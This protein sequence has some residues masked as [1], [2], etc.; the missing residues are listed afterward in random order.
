MMGGRVGQALHTVNPFSITYFDCAKWGGGESGGL[1]KN[2][3]M[4]T[5]IFGCWGGGRGGKQQLTN[6]M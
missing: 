2:M 5:R 6:V 3:V 4:V 1:S